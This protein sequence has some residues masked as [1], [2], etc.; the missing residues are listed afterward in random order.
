[1]EALD[2]RVAMPSSVSEPTALPR[3]VPLKVSSHVFLMK[4]Y[5]VVDIVIAMAALVGAFVL[6]NSSQM[7]SGL[8]EFLG[9]R[10]TIKNLVLLGVFA[11]IWA[12]VC[13]RLD[14]YDGPRLNR[15][16]ILRIA[17][18]C[19]GGSSFALLFPL[20]SHSRAFR[21]SAVLWLWP[22]TTSLSVLARFLINPLA[23][24]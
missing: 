23:G 8:E 19:A 3:R 1:M 13:S 9:L 22:V 18:A 12:S 7:P 2:K 24:E 17:T 20:T 10:V 6:T 4:L 5:R 14:L 16:G 21:L 11:F 15:V